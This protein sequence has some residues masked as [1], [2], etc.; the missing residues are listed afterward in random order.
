MIGGFMTIGSPEKIIDAIASS[1]VK[2]LTIIC[3]D[4]GCLAKE[5]ASLSKLN[6]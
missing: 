2:K 3:N 1:G 5:L 4:A 6:R